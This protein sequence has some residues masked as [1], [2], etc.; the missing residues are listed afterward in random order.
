MTYLP[1]FGG[2]HK[3]WKTSAAA[4]ACAAL[5]LPAVSAHAQARFG[6]IVNKK[7]ATV[8]SGPQG[9][10]FVDVPTT[11]TAAEESKLVG[12][13]ARREWAAKSRALNAQVQLLRRAGYFKGTAAI[14]YSSVIAV[15]KNGRLVTPSLQKKTGRAFPGGDLTFKFT[16]FNATTQAFL[17]Q[18]VNLA[19][20]RIVA[21]YGQ[22]AQSGEVEI[23]NVGSFDTSQIP[24]VQRF[25]FGGYDVSNNRILLPIFDSADTTAHALLL[26]MVHA[27]HGPAVFQYDAWEQGFARAASAI[28]ARDP[29]FGFADASANNQYSLLK[30]YDLLN[31]PALG[32]N[33][34][35]PPSQAGISLD[36]QTGIGKMLAPRLGMS[37]AAWLKVYI[38]NP[39]FFRDFNKAYYAAVDPA[40]SPSLAGNIPALRA[41]AA[42]LLP[43]GVEAQPWSRW[44]ETQYVLDTSVSVGTKLYAFVVPGLIDS[45][46]KQSALIVLV[47]YRTQNTGDETLLNGTAFATYFDSTNARINLGGA[48]EQTA[49]SAGEGFITTQS[50]FTPNSSATR[51]TM[52]FHIGNAAAR[53]YLPLGFQ[54]DFQAVVLGPNN[55]G[56][57][58]VTQTTLPPVRNYSSTK[59]LDSAAFAAAL[60]SGPN[61]LAVTTV[62]IT[63]GGNTQTFRINTGDGAYYAVLKSGLS[64]GGVVTL[65]KTFPFNT[66]PQL[67]SFPVQPLQTSVE[68]ALGL[69]A[70]DF[71]LSYWDPTRPVYETVIP[72]Q[73]SVAPLQM[74]RGYWLKVAPV[75]LAQNTA[76]SVTGAAPPTDTDFT[77][78][79]PFGWNQVGSPFSGTI[80]ISRVLVQQLQND[81]ISWDEAVTR[82]L[83]LAQP[84]GFDPATGYQTVS[85]FDGTNWKGYWVRVLAPTGVTLL[86]PGPDSVTTRATK[87]RAQSVVYNTRPDWQVRLQVRSSAQNVPFG[88]VASAT[89]GGTRQKRTRA[90]DSRFDRELP[91]SIVPAVGLGFVRRDGGASAGG[92]LIGDFRPSPAGASVSTRETWD[93]EAV[94]PQD[95]TMTLTWDG[96]GTLAR[97]TRLTLYDK[98]SGTQTSLRSRSSYTW[99]GEAGKTRSL[100]IVA[101][102]ALTNPLTI[103]NVQF[104]RTRAAGG[105]NGGGMVIGYGLTGDAEVSVD[106]LQLG[107]RLVRR[108]AGGRAQTVG[109]QSVHWDGRAENGSGLPA[110]TYQITITAKSV[111]GN[112]TAQQTRTVT[113]LR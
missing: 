50:F 96:L 112:Q 100:Q 31:Q 56:T 84:F 43:N 62:Q 4:L 22:P 109:Q 71:L 91:P 13:A 1:R 23:V 70:Q 21:V 87:T 108:L 49:I 48:A 99:S 42:P 66:I 80:D 98:T 81:A 28:V 94:T 95:G 103:N 5:V 67:V 106:V 36:G 61:D 40:Q 89:L 10:L 19:Y 12:E 79:C 18:V 83:V 44:Y 97:N 29:A 35:F 32:N 16:G 102:P 110:G 63:N 74:G 39:A 52:D 86:L 24:E 25:A 33:T 2:F 26:N 47:H 77:I 76:I 45:T 64:G 68:A 54:G 105:V 30:F 69:S 65:S 17:Q 3:P 7:F 55:A 57:A 51:V 90:L 46:G 15:R 38:E 9:T 85:G 82:N 60:G 59:T 53:S 111:D 41:L 75:S 58:T 8:S 101:E 113:L 20:P 107:G 73:P 6:N 92:R 11:A 14:P 37:G 78:S 34:F 88:G 72:G 104:T 93:I 27:F